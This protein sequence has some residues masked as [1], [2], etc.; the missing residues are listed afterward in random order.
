MEK[1][2]NISNFNGMPY[3]HIL[4][5]HVTNETLT[6]KDAIIL[7]QKGILKESDFTK[8]PDGY[9]S[10]ETIQENINI[11]ENVSRETISEKRKYNKSK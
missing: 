7:L 2:T 6:D 10:R 9:V 4:G 5:K 8:L 1:K 11:D 3:F